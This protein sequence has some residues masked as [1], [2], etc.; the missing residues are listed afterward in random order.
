MEILFFFL[1]AVWPQEKLLSRRSFIWDFSWE[2]WNLILRIMFHSKLGRGLFFHEL[3]NCFNWVLNAFCLIL[4]RNYFSKLPEPCW[5]RCWVCSFS[6]SLK[7]TLLFSLLA[8]FPFQ[9]SESFWRNNNI[10]GQ[11]QHCQSLS[12]KIT[13]GLTLNYRWQVCQIIWSKTKAKVRRLIFQMDLFGQQAFMEHCMKPSLC[14]VPENTAI[15]C[16]ELAVW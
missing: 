15:I 4:W 8:F 9:D 14:Q 3:G 1:L 6:V 2:K 12:C 13:P 10:R 7:L 5:T 16:K 11:G